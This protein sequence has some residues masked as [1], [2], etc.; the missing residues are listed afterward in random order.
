MKYTDVTVSDSIKYIGVNDYDL[1]LFEGQYIIPNG[2]AYN[3]YVILD[4][5]ITIM[6]TVKRHLTIL[7]FSIWS[8]TMLP[9]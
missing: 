1:D 5:K 7:L 8:R 2:V 3:S 4:D 9:A 6:D